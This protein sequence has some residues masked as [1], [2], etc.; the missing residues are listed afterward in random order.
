[1]QKKDELGDL[2][3]QARDI[4]EKIRQ[5][6]IKNWVNKHVKNHTLGWIQ[7][8]EAHY[9]N[10]R[11]IYAITPPIK[12]ISYVCRHSVAVPVSDPQRN[13]KSSFIEIEEYFD[14]DGKHMG[15]VFT[16]EPSLIQ[17]P[18]THVLL[19]VWVKTEK[20]VKRG[21]PKNAIFPADC[22]LIEFI[23][24]KKM[25]GGWFTTPPDIREISQGKYS[26]DGC[27]FDD[28]GKKIKQDT[29]DKTQTFKSGTI[30][31]NNKRSAKTSRIITS[32]EIE[33]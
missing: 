18:K 5:T 11:T 15:H 7:S 22:D 31:V 24:P 28:S 4:Q 10:L 30:K 26:V 9:L 2:M 32:K 21:E 33:M 8:A 17:Y 12:G 13:C 14:A 23:K 25:R 16:D 20:P 3:N 27:L 6:T 29:L 19:T 1:M